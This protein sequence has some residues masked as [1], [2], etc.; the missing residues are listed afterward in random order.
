M[1]LP[2]NAR[3]AAIA[4]GLTTLL[5]ACSGG[6]PTRI[7]SAP[8][9][10]DAFGPAAD[11]PQVLGEPFT[12]EGELYTPADMLSYD[13]VGY[14]TFDTGAGQ[15]VTV[16]HKTLPLPSYVEI[17]SLESGRTILARVERRGPMTSSRLVALSPGALAQLGIVEGEPVRVRRVNPPEFERAEL[18]AGRAG[19]ERLETPDTLLAVLKQ[20]LPAA[21]AASL[22][23]SEGSVARVSTL[24]PMHVAPSVRR[25]A[26][27]TAT[28][29]E[30]A[31][32]RAFTAQR[33]ANTSYPLKPMPAAAS[34]DASPATPQNVAVS[35]TSQ[36]RT[37]ELPGRRTPTAAPIRTG[38]AIADTSP[39]TG[40]KFV[41]QAAA[42]ANKA[43]AERLADR[44]DG[45]V[46]PSGD[47]FRV[48]TGPYATRG[49]AEAALAKV[50]A[51][52]Y[53]DARVFSAG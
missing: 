26:P 5:A 13:M 37:F 17:T 31:F 7:A 46:M 20:K 3:D 9:A 14:A 50:R 12:V 45:F 44:I 23:A 32:D 43:N 47:Y 39:A 6:E 11:Y 15:G 29:K 22:A 2:G 38:S 24:A 10:T 21:G 30:T 51:A 35:N 33:S 25:G 18:R 1:R 8:Q 19:P 4:L 42:F 40:G 36:M 34:A 41:V 27:I 49:Q 48:R 53:S 52:G 16:A 28:P